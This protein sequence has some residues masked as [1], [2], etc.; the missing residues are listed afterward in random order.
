MKKALSVTSHWGWGETIL[1]GF[2]VAT[3]AKQD[4]LKRQKIARHK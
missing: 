2:L 4:D 3:E 1:S